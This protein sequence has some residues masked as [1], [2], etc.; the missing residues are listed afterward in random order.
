VT[1]SPR[2]RQA[3]DAVER[4][5]AARL[6]AVIRTDEFAHATAWAA[7]AQSALR[8]QVDAAS[9]RLWHLVNLPAGSDISRLRVQ[10]GELDREVRRL[11]LQL[12]Q[13]A[14]S[15][16]EVTDHADPAEPSRR[17]GP[18]APRGRAQRPAGP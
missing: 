6:E 13:H 3:Y 1:G 18:R 4:T 16:E 14:E 8:S 2:W 12:A 5:V 15:T 10:V 11:T 7:R 9:A 17:A